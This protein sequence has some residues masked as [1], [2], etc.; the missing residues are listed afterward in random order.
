[1]YLLYRLLGISAIIGSTVC[2]LIMVPLQFL[3]GKKM[4]DNA[5]IT[6]VSVFHQ[7]I[8]FLHFT[9]R[10]G[11]KHHFR[12]SL[13]YILKFLSFFF[14]LH[15]ANSDDRL[16][17]ISELLIGIKVIKLNAWEKVFKEKIECS[18]KTELEYLNKDSF[19]WTL[20]SK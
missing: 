10:K 15:Q 2:I 12:I 5:K 17:R 14:F 6:A 3:I 19:Y 20:M 8:F 7:N 18:R 16:R 4:S 13:R 9:Q 11:K 1:M